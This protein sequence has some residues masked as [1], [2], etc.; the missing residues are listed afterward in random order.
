MNIWM[1]RP[2]IYDEE[3]GW[4]WHKSWILPTL[5]IK[6]EI[7]DPNTKEVFNPPKNTYA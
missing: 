7:I 3:L 2:F 1:D 4:N 5:C 6:L